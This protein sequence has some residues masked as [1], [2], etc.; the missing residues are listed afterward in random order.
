ML[1]QGTAA[2]FVAVDVDSSEVFCV[3]P[4]REALAFGVVVGVLYTGG[5]KV[6]TS[7]F[8]ATSK[9]AFVT[10]PLAF[11][12]RPKPFLLSVNHVS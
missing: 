6:A 3:C 4:A 9:G 12:G 2:P 8:D 11:A 10:V 7:G 5:V 1:V